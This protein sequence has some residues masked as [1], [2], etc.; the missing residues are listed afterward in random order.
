MS[1]VLLPLHPNP[2]STSDPSKRLY[3]LPEIPPTPRRD[4]ESPLHALRLRPSPKQGFWAPD[5][6]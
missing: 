5:R 2:C 4:I 3:H 1:L 6:K